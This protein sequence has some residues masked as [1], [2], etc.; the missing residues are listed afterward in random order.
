MFNDLSSDPDLFKGQG[1]Y[2][3]E[4]YRMMREETR[5]EHT[6]LCTTLLLICLLEGESC[7]TFRIATVHVP[8]CALCEDFSSCFFRDN[9]KEH[10]PYTNVLWTSYLCDKLLNLTRYKDQGSKEHQT[11]QGEFQNFQRQILEHSSSCHLVKECP[12]FTEN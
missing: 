9:W 6:N 12:F 2:Q 3:F 4:I 10:H 11:L 5:S 7:L 1:D 8:M